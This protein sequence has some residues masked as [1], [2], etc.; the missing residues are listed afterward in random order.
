MR[1]PTAFVALP[2][3]LAFLGVVSAVPAASPLEED[4]L[5]AGKTSGIVCNK[6]HQYGQ[7]GVSGLEGGW[8]DCAPGTTCLGDLCVAKLDAAGGT[9][10]PAEESESLSEELP[11]PFTPSAKQELGVPTPN[12][13]A[14]GGIQPTQPATSSNG[15]LPISTAPGVHPAVPEG[16]ENDETETEN[17]SV[18]LT[19]AT[20]TGTPPLKLTLPTETAHPQTPAVPMIENPS[21]GAISS[22]ST[23]S[24]PSP[25]CKPDYYNKCRSQP[26]YNKFTKEG[27]RKVA[28]WQTYDG[29]A[30]ETSEYDYKQLQGLTHLILFSVSMAKVA[31]A[32]EIGNERTL[33]VGVVDAARKQNIAV[34]VAFGGWDLDALYKQQ[35]TADGFIALGNKIADF[36]IDG[37]Y[38]GIDI[39]HEY[40]VASQSQI[41]PEM[42]KAISKRCKDRGVPDMI[43]S[44][45]LPGVPVYEPTDP[46]KPIEYVLNGY[47]QELFAAIDSSVDFY[48]LMTYPK[49]FSMPNATACDTSKGLGCLFQNLT[50]ES[51]GTYRYR[52]DY[53][54]FSSDWSIPTQAFFNQSQ[55]SIQEYINGKDGSVTAPTKEYYDEDFK[56]DTFYDKPR[57]IFWT[58]QGPFAIKETC[59]ALKNSGVGGQMAFA[60]GMDTTDLPHWSAWINCVKGWKEATSEQEAEVPTAQRE[61]EVPTGQQ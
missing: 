30:K 39:D 9:P 1:F 46:S 7:C 19:L 10:A 40:P 52:P 27:P 55:L 37:G 20:E 15:V 16:S 58:W 4:G 12:I 28:Y 36:A 14:D 29:V 3:V 59:E 35:T 61:S 26:I 22:N 17:P 45:A 8:R 53:N 21:D 2:A 6:Q 42:I 50:E 60:V 32:W 13:P 57:E 25:E 24:V 5:C 44:V 38:D 48:N 11:S 18:K 54:W 31:P 41:W 43:I 33:P 23:T 47:T 51:S 49:S 34:M 56:A